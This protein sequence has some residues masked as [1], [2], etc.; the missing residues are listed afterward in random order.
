MRGQKAW[1]LL[2]ALLAVS[3]ARAVEKASVTVAAAASLQDA[4]GEIARAFERTHAVTVTITYGGSGRLARQIRAGAPIDVFLC[5]EPSL[6]TPLA[7]EKRVVGERAFATNRLVVVVPASSRDVPK[8]LAELNEASYRRIGIGQPGYVPAGRYAK[9]VLERAG[10]YERLKGRFVYGED[11]RQVLAYV[12][13]GEVDAGLVYRTD[14]RGRRA[15]RIAFEIPPL[16]DVPITYAAAITAQAKNPSEARA[17]VD[18]LAGREA[19]AI[20]ARYGFGPAPL[21]RPTARR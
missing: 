16:K 10:L 18:L 14:A 13:H 8:T 6:I 4:L 7:R 1:I 5:A 17:F 19:Q 11:V 21:A 15:A 20:L 3:P 12:E 9:A 2:L